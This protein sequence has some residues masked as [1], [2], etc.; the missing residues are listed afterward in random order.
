MGV[1]ES[2]EDGFLGV[3]TVLGLVK[4]EIGVGFHDFLGDFFAAIGGQAVHDEGTGFGVSEEGGVD[5]PGTQDFDAF[6]GFF[7]LAHADPDIGVNGICTCDRSD[8]VVGD[9]EVG[10][11]RQSGEEAGGGLEG[12]GRTDDHVK[13]ATHGGPNPGPGN[14][15][16]AIAQKDDALALPGTESFLNGQQ[17]GEDLA[18]VL[19][20]GEGVD[21]GD[22]GV[23]GKID[24]V[25]LGEGA[26]D[27]AVNHAAEDA[28]GVLDGLT[29]AELDVDTGKE[30]GGAAEFA[31]ADLKADASTSGGLGENERPLLAG[32]DFGGVCAGALQA[33]A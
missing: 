12:F 16:I 2:D 27:S 17:V 31:D 8:G 19:V 23:V 33:G 5:L 13:T 32:E 11:I 28:G 29:A 25:L 10:L 1:G 6:F 26:D 9:G 24:H 15:A 18:G 21:G 22:A 7:F 14:V 20:V 30:H 4:D 3:Q